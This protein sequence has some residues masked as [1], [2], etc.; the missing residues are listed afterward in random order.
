[1]GHEVTAVSDGPSAVIALARDDA[2]RLAIVDWMMPGADGLEV[3]RAVRDGSGPYVY[4]ILLTAREGSEN[5]VEALDAGADDFVTKPFNAAELRA[6]LRAGA[7]VLDL[8]ENLLKAQEALRAEAARDSVTG[9]WNRGMI[10][11]Q[12]RREVRRAKHERRPLAV[13]LA[14][15][16][17]F[18]KVND[19]R[20]HAAGDEVLQQTANRIKL[21]LRDYDFVGRYGGEEFLVVLPGCDEALARM[22]GERIREKLSESP[23]RTGEHCLTVTASIGLAWTATAEEQPAALVAAADAALY[24]AK[25]KGRDRLES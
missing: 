16:D 10:E 13:L 15:I 5:M 25:A 14:D 7:R 19:T 22:V 21:A 20:G 6:R 2:L 8:Q 24:R 17:H 1:M 11:E 23:M 18:K 12:L 4:L 3:C 9:L